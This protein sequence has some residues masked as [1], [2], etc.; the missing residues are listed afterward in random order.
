V[1]RPRL[2]SVKGMIA[3]VIQQLDAL[4]ADEKQSAAKRANAV[5]VKADLLSS[6]LTSQSNETRARIKHGQLDD[7]EK[8]EKPEKQ[9]KP[10]KAEPQTAQSESFDKRLARLTGRN[11][12]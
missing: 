1:R 6:L 5:F 10:E 9:Q 11:N 8:D 3:T 12:A 4:A 2:K 7:D